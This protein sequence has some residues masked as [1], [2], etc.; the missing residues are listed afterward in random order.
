MV[1][2]ALPFDPQNPPFAPPQGTA[3]PATW[4]LAMGLFRAHRPE[5]DVAEGEE[6][7]CRTCEAV[8]PCGARELALRGL[9]DAYLHDR[10]VPTRPAAAAPPPPPV[11]PPVPQESP[12]IVVPAV[13]AAVVP[14]A[15]ADTDEV[16]LPMPLVAE[17]ESLP[18]RR[19]IA[20]RFR[21]HAD[22]EQQQ[23]PLH[24]SA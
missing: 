24:R 3:Q 21:R 6:A 7:S 10:V 23:Q 12:T 18:L 15:M 14:A 8:W 5:G 11:A 9:I 1:S 22:E 2:Q 19:R 16:P 4:R 13:P 17:S 20:R